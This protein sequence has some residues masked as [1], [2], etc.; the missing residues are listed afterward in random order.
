MKFLDLDVKG[1]VLDLDGTLLDSTGLWGEID[2]AF[3]GKRGKELPSTYGQEIAHIGLNAAACYTRTRYFPNEEEEDILNEWKQMSLKAYAEELPLKKGAK[4]FLDVLSSKGIPMV[5]ATANSPHLYLPALKRLGI[6][7]YFLCFLD[8]ETF[9]EGKSN[10]KMYEE[11]AKRIGA[12]KENILI[13]EDSLSPIKAARANGFKVI[14]I[15]DKY[16][17]S[18]IELYKSS[19]TYFVMDWDETLGMIQD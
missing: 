6:E 17:T 7:S 4:E 15:Y 8:A 13:F 18:D 12:K 16:S 14:G 11:A 1:V 9:K 19:S 3:F 5:L 2:K 10:G